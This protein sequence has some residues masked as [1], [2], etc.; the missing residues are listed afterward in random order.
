MEDT[1]QYQTER[2]DRLVDS[3]NTIALRLDP[4]PMLEEIKRLLLRRTKYDKDSDKYIRPDCLKPM[5]DEEGIEELMLELRARIGIPSVL[6]KLNNNK[7]NEIVR[8]TGEMILEF[9]NFNKDKF[10]IQESD[11]GRIFF[12]IKH[13]VDIFLRRAIEGTENKLISKGFVSKENVHRNMVSKDEQDN[14]GKGFSLF[15]GGW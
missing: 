10:H 5:F 4:T 2:Y 7:I 8:E 13:N 3:Y 11:F 1:E 12:L 6:S 15:K 14:T 9:I